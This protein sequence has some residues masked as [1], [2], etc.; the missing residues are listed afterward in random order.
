[1][2]GTFLK[3]AGDI[4]RLTMTKLCARGKNAAKRKFKVYPSA[5]ANAYASKICA[6]KIKDPSGLKR[7]D[8]KGPKKKMAGGKKVGK[9]QGKIA[10]GCGAIM[11]NKRKRTKYA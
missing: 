10:K 3:I 9:P 5:Y 2:F 8:F 4:G 7:K 11:P 6:G 1:V